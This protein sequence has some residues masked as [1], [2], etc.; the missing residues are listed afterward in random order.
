VAE[1][2][3]RPRFQSARFTRLK[4]LGMQRLFVCLKLT[5]TALLPIRAHD[6]P[7]A[8]YTIVSINVFFFSVSG[9]LLSLNREM[10]SLSNISWWQFKYDG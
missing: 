2:R 7:N 6:A 4:L 10:L 1:Q 8:N 3:T 5:E 9:L